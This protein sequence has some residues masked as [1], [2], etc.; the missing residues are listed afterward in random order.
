MLGNQ[1]EERSRF[2]D[3][4]GGCALGDPPTVFEESIDKSYEKR[5]NA[6][7]EIE[8]I[9]KRLAMVGDHDKITAMMN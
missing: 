2:C 3:S 8:E 4:H 7:R 9:V 6:A 1:G 5:K